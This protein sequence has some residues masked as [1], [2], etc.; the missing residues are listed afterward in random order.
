[1][2]TPPALYPPNTPADDVPAFVA[3]LPQVRAVKVWHPSKDARHENVVLTA[4]RYRARG[5]EVLHIIDAKE[6]VV[7]GSRRAELSLPRAA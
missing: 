4:D 6:L 3:E 7:P 2:Y 5:W 1:M